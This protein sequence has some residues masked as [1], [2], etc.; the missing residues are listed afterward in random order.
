MGRRNK[1]GRAARRQDEGARAGKEPRRQASDRTP[2]QP[3]R[4]AVRWKAGQPDEDLHRLILSSVGYR[5][6]G[7]A[8]APSSLYPHKTLPDGSP[9]LSF[10]NGDGP[11]PVP[12]DTPKS[13]ATGRHRGGSTSSSALVSHALDEAPPLLQLPSRISGS[14]SVSASATSTTMRAGSAHASVQSTSSVTTTVVRASVAT[15]TGPTERVW[16]KPDLTIDNVQRLKHRARDVKLSAEKLQDAHEKRRMLLSSC[17]RYLMYTWAT[18]QDQSHRKDAA[19]EM[20][21]TADYI[22][23]HCAGD[24]MDWITVLGLRLCAAARFTAFSRSV[25]NLVKHGREILDSRRPADSH[26]VLYYVGESIES[27]RAIQ[28]WTKAANYEGSLRA[29]GEESQC[30]FLDKLPSLTG[31]LSEPLGS[32]LGRIVDACAELLSLES[33]LVSDGEGGEEE[34]DEVF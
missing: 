16:A 34:D 30:A 5:A 1:R 15:A 13:G 8:S 12:V 18:W 23:R 29:I 20:R 9:R 2:T 24:S 11:P 31:A 21:Q 17:V 10:A 22:E 7:S 19:R 27:A 33:E 6:P 26:V 25:D 14:V 32:V 4:G 28:L 3:Q